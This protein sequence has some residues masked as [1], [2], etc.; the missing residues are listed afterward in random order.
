VAVRPDFVWVGRTGGLS[1]GPFHVLRADLFSRELAVELLDLRHQIGIRPSDLD[2]SIP[3]TEFPATTDRIVWIE[4]ADDDACDSA[5]DDSFG[6]WD[7]GAVARRAWF[8]R[9]EKG[10]TRQHLVP[11]LGF[12]KRELGVVSGGEF[13]SEGLAQ[14]YTFPRDDSSDLG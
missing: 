13:A 2:A 7:L 3:E 8:Q 1:F 6:A 9:R 14:H 4:H 11:E 10:R 12:E 5:F